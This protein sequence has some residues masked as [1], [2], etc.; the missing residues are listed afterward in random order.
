MTTR[1]RSSSRTAILMCARCGRY[2]EHYYLAAAHT[3]FSY[4]SP[5]D[6]CLHEASGV[7]DFWSCRACKTK[8]I[9]GAPVDVVDSWTLREEKKFLASVAVRKKDPAAWLRAYARGVRLRHWGFGGELVS[10]RTQ[11]ALVM[12]AEELAR[13]AGRSC[14]ASAGK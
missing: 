7:K 12:C 11:D 5:R 14:T 6:E 3:K 10:G 1:T 4:D 8:R 9:Y 13:E 2:T